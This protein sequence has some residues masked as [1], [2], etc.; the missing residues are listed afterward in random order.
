MTTKFG[1]GIVFSKAQVPAKYNRPTSTATLFFEYWGDENLL[2]PSHTKPKWPANSGGTIVYNY[3]CYVRRRGWMPAGL[4][5]L[6]CFSRKNLKIPWKS[7]GKLMEFSFSKMWPP[8]VLHHYIFI[9]SHLWLTSHPRSTVVLLDT[10]TS[11]TVVP[12]HN[13]PLA[14]HCR[15]QY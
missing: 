12:R 2:L 10:G 11:G 15:A 7:Q 14:L 3:P 5:F 9:I 4:L 8:C 13:F 6:S 1:I